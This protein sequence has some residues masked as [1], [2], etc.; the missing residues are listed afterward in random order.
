MPHAMSHMKPLER[1]QAGISGA[2]TDTSAERGELRTERLGMA[3]ALRV[4][5][6]ANSLQARGARVFLCVPS[7]PSDGRLRSSDMRAS[8]AVLGSMARAIPGMGPRSSFESPQ[9]M[10]TTPSAHRK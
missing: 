9:S 6:S 5:A 1:S 10:D 7:A 3:H 2:Q 8:P 4:H